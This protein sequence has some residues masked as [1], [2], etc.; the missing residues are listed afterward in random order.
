MG[1]MVKLDKIY[2]RG[3]DEGETSLVTGERVAKHSPRPSAFG[4]VDE[5]NSLLG[6][7]RTLSTEL[8]DPEINAMLA[9]IQNDLF[10]LGADLATPEGKPPKKAED[11]R[12]TTRQVK[13][14]EDE[15]DRMNTELEP[16]N[17]FVLPGGVA[18]A[19]HIHVARAQTRRAERSITALAAQDHVGEP[20]L[21]YINRLSD[22]LFVMARYVNNKGK[23]DILWI[24]GLNV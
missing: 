18:A 23:H 24:P 11:L 19:A 16:L 6:I 21:Q 9:R 12:I 14:L 3:G 20:A 13:R 4:A 2:T 22:H 8:Q 10:D 7:C 5:L 1:C 15:I 17:S